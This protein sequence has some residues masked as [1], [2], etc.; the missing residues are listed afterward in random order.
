MKIPKEVK[1]LCPKCGKHTTHKVTQAKTKGLSA[2]HTLSR[3]SRPRMHERQQGKGM[4]T[5]NSGK[6]SRPPIKNRKMSGKKLSKKTDIRYQ[7]KD[8]K[9]ITTQAEGT[10]AKKVELI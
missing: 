6:T 9:R 1:R 8:C 3:G 5:G 2:T 4:G 7:C 10:R